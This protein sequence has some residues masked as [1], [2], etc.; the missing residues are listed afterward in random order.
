MANPQQILA[1]QKAIEEHKKRIEELSSQVDLVQKQSSEAMTS[2]K[3]VLVRK[4][5]RDVEEEEELEFETKARTVLLEQG[6]FNNNG[7]LTAWKT[8][9]L[10][11]EQ[12]LEVL[13]KIVLGRHENMLKDLWNQQ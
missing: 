3:R 8:E 10:S 9:G 7:R 6:K 4:A 2:V 5:G 11:V 12:R 13:E 1:Q